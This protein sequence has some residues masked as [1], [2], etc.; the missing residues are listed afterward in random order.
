MFFSDFVHHAEVAR[1]IS[2]ADIG[3]IPYERVGINHYLCSPSKLFHY[4][5]A[6]IPVACSDFPFLRKVV[7]EN[8]VGAVF[9]P[10]DPEASP[11]RYAR[12]SIRRTP[13][14]RTRSA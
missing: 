12:S 6:E 11:R 4:I 1:F 8:G 3:L 7:L 9:D 2:S 10:S 13:V 14:R 5:M